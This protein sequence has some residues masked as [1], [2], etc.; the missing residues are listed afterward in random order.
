MHLERQRRTAAIF[1]MASPVQEPQ[2]MM[3][4][5]PQPALVMP[6]SFGSASSQ[7]EHSFRHSGAQ[8]RQEPAA[9]ESGVPVVIETPGIVTDSLL[10]TDLLRAI[11]SN[12]ELAR[13]VAD[14][15]MSVSNLEIQVSDLQLQLQQQEWERELPSDSPQAQHFSLTP[16]V[17]PVAA[18]LAEWYDQ[19]PARATDLATQL[20]TIVSGAG[21]H[22]DPSVANHGLPRNAQG[23]LSAQSPSQPLTD[24]LSGQQVASAVDGGQRVTE[25]QGSDVFSFLAGPQPTR[26]SVPSDPTRVHDAGGALP[27]VPHLQ[28]GCQTPSLPTGVE[29]LSAPPGLVAAAA[30]PLLPT[31]AELGMILKAIQTFLN[32]LPKLELGDV[33]TRATRL[34]T[35]KATV[36]QALIPTGNH[37]RSWWRWCLQSAHVAYR[38]F[39][40]A[41]IQERE[42]ILPLD[43][44]PT[45]WE[46]IDS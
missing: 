34:L 15:Q 23:Q 4:A 10:R 24:V 37:L 38:R 25:I 44:L 26:S 28:L 36:E 3:P 22:V 35:W 21:I 8:L 42:S 6:S 12:E 7:A 40:K 20:S 33:A 29:A 19:P 18:D 39:L 14:L 31:S 17:E 1:E 9:L 11:A 5:I 30:S 32:D 45:E 27:I 16:R 41:S 13:A 46:Q 2:A 43:L